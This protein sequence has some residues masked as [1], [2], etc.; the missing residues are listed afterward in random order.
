MEVYKVY[1][2]TKDD[3]HVSEVVVAAS[4]KKEAS[5]RALGHVKKSNAY[6]GVRTPEEAQ[7]VSRVLFVKKAGTNGCLVIHR[8]PLEVFKKVKGIS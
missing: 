2:H 1:L 5:D 4:S 7:D 6:K 8:I 3:P